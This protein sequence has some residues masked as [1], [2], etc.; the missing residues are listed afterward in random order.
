MNTLKPLEGAIY[1]IFNMN[2]TFYYASADSCEMPTEDFVTLISLYEKFGYDLIIAYEAILRGH[3]PQIPEFCTSSFYEAK[4]FLM[5]NLSKTLC[6]SL[7][8]KRANES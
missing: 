5:S 2:D 6:P 7:A 8:R 4:S 1:I 3:D